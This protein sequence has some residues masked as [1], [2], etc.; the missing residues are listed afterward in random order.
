MGSGRIVGPGDRP[1]RV[2]RIGACLALFATA[3]LPACSL[4]KLAA[5]R[6]GSALGSGNSVYASDDDPELVGDALPFALKTIESLLAASP[7]NSDLLLSAAS[8]YTQYAYAYLQ[9]EADY[10]E[11]SDLSRAT[12]LRGRATR[13]YRRALGYGLRGLDGRHD[14][15]SAAF[16]RDPS[17]ALATMT[18]K[19]VPLLY[20]TGTAW[21]A[22]IASAKDDADLAADLPAVEAIMRRALELDAGF[23]EGA[24]WEFFISYDGGRPAAGGGSPEKARAAF[25]EAVAASRGRR[26]APY[27]SL[28]ETVALAAQDRAEFRRLLDAALAIDPDAVP[29]QRLANLIAQKRARWLLARTDELF[30]E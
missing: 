13:M 12:E 25:D 28:A 4:S 24:I 3:L 19:D 11:A 8:G 9:C 29:D 7:E 14:G 17:A 27:V 2:A 22:A 1:G 16:R 26:A 5:D 20:W 23:G 30:L 10:V 18:A 6:L 21:G 15:F